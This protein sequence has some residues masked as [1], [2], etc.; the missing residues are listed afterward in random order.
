MKRVGH[1][2]YEW[3][4]KEMC[5]FAE[6]VRMQAVYLRCPACQIKPSINVYIIGS[7]VSDICKTALFGLW[8]SNTKIVSVKNI[9][10]ALN[11]A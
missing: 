7:A 5:R 4:E 1:G 11:W 10:Q 3:E 8:K 2:G 6:M 9:P